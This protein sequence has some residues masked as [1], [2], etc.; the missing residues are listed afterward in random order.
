MLSVFAYKDE[1]FSFYFFSLL[2][3]FCFCFLHEHKV[4]VLYFKSK[5]E[6]MQGFF[7]L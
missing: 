6:K 1:S 5:V 4:P 7:L 2:I 3:Q